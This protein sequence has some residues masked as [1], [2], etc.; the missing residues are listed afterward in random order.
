MNRNDKLL[1]DSVYRVLWDIFKEGN[2]TDKDYHPELEEI[3]K[4]L[5]ITSKKLIK[6]IKENI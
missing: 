1:E 3:N 2:R 5:R 4:R 6:F